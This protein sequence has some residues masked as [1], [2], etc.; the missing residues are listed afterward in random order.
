MRKSSFKLGAAFYDLFLW[1]I[2][3]ILGC[4]GSPYYLPSKLLSAL[5]IGFYLDFNN[6]LNYLKQ[7]FILSWMGATLYTAA[8]SLNGYWCSM[9]FNCAKVWSNEKRKIAFC[10]SMFIHKIIVPAAWWK[11]DVIDLRCRYNLWILN[12]LLTTLCH[13]LSSQ[14]IRH[15][16]EW[17]HAEKYCRQPKNN[18]C[19]YRTHMK[20]SK[21]T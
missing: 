6:C 2:I 7:H 19:A 8:N 5:I 18:E 9:I 12:Q 1:I 21:N 16:C 11:T 15:F 14:S 10:G 4:A 20:V 13:W 17:V 3:G